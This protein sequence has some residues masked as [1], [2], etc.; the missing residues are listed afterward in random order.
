MTEQEPTPGTTLETLPPFDARKF[1]ERLLDLAERAV[2]ETP[3]GP[4][5]LLPGR[6]GKKY[7]ASL[8]PSVV[9]WLGQV[10]TD[11]PNDTKAILNAV[12]EFFDDAQAASGSDYE[13]TLANVSL[14]AKAADLVRRMHWEINALRDLTAELTRRCVELSTPRVGDV[15]DA[16]CGGPDRGLLDC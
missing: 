15:S 4:S 2:L 16:S 12:G 11:Y 8:E 9:A 10:L 14:G 3:G 5:R 6:D 7:W 1:K 13:T